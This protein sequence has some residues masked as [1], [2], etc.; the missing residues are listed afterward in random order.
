MQNK[1]GIEKRI[2]KRVNRNRIEVAEDEAE[3]RFINVTEI[4]EDAV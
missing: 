3:K 2:E 1:K 4:S